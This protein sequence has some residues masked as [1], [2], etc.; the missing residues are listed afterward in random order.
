M[1]ASSENATIS[2]IFTCVAISL[3]TSFLFKHR[4]LYNLQQQSFAHQS[5]TLSSGPF[6]H[7]TEEEPR[8]PQK[9]AY[10]ELEKRIV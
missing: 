7:L 1:N 4:H 9:E 3:I 5:C 6:F 8:D 10:F 2:M